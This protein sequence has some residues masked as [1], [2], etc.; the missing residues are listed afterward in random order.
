VRRKNRVSHFA[1]DKAKCDILEFF[2]Y[3]LCA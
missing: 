1:L 2:S 3:T